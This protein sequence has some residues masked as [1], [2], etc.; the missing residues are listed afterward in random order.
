MVIEDPQALHGQISHE[1]PTLGLKPTISV[2]NIVCSSAKAVVVQRWWFLLA[3]LP[4]TST[5]RTAEE[6]EHVAALCTLHMIEKT[7]ALFI[8][9]SSAAVGHVESK[10]GVACAITTAPRTA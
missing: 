8:H 9:A 1:R 7:G 2:V 10:R 6:Y 4:S 5:S 3:Y